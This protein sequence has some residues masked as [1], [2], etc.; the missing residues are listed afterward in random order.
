MYSNCQTTTV[1]NISSLPNDLIDFNSENVVDHSPIEIEVPM[2]NNSKPSLHST[3]LKTSEL[4]LSNKTS[5]ISAFEKYETTH[6]YIHS[7][8]VLFP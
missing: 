4:I 2:K 7:S 3:P 6:V 5:M 1:A 8:A